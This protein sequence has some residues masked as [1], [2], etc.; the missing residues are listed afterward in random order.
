MRETR[1]KRQ[2]AWEGAALALALDSDIASEPGVPSVLNRA[3][4]PA[5]NGE[6]ILCGPSLAPEV[7]SHPRAVIVV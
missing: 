7:E 3:H 5:P 1:S 4:P 2:N 6:M